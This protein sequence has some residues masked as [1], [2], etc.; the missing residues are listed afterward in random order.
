MSG[1]AGIIHFDQS[2]V[3]G[4]HLKQMLAAMQ[5]SNPLGGNTY[6]AG[7]VGL[8]QTL[9]Q[10]APGP[11]Q[12]TMPL[13]H[14]SGRWILV[15]DGRIDNREE[16][17]N[18][19]DVP[20][21]ERGF[22]SDGPLILAA[23][24]KWGQDCPMHLIGD[25][26]LAVWDQRDRRLFCARDHFGV[27][28]FLYSSSEQNFVFASNAEAILI[29]R[30]A[31]HRIKEARIADFLLDLEGEDTTSTFYEDIYRLPHGHAMIV[32]AGEV[33]LKQYWTL[34]PMQ[35]DGIKTEADYLEEFSF[36]ITEA[37]RCRLQSLNCTAV[38]LSGGLDSS[39]IFGIARRI[40]TQEDPTH[41]ITS[42]LIS[43]IDP[44]NLETGYI[45]ALIK[46]KD[47]RTLTVSLSQVEQQ[48]DQLMN[49]LLCAGEPFD[50]HMNIWRALYEQAREQHILAFLDGVDGDLLLADSNLAP[51]LWRSGQ[52]RAAIGETLLAGNS[53]AYY[54]HPLIR[55][56]ISLRVAFTPE[57]LRRLKRKFRTSNAIS[58]AVKGSIINPEFA[59]SVRLDERLEKYHSHNR[60]SPA[61]SQMEAHRYALNNPHLQAALE[62][63][64]RVASGYS[65][66][67]RHPLLDVRLVEFCLSLPWQL[68]THRGWRK[69]AMRRVMEPML[70]YEVVW[71]NDKHHLGWSVNLMVLKSQADYF[72]QLL[73]ESHDVLAAYIDLKKMENLWT[74]FFSSGG[75]EPAR[76][77][78]TA[79]ALALWLR[80]QKEIY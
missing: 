51:F 36:R 44:D 6:L 59:R 4:K 24:E 29:A 34:S 11:I 26:A 74:Q 9:L 2:S 22:Y 5:V 25:F 23:Y 18:Q 15:F 47:F 56:Y 63:Y 12:E 64:D 45:Q 53:M 52:V 61:S 75:D 69:M 72:Q 71:R 17:H 68:K 73:D 78:W 37:V 8:G 58:E 21:P 16:L 76:L 80:R 38:S 14:P 30:E 49:Q 33:R 7:S 43:P 28:P 62:R 20:K 67:S 55:L 48:T 57:W 60:T 13:V 54:N 79:I 31:H 10:A 40:S 66:E 19:L 3:E 27:K 39:I 70:P 65:I 1:I 42:S 35:I 77:I 50:W 41:L 32:K 46:D